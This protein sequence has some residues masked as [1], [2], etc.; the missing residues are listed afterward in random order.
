MNFGNFLPQAAQTYCLW[1]A[2]GVRAEYVC[3]VISYIYCKRSQNIYVIAQNKY[4]FALISLSFSVSWSKS[5]LFCCV[6]PQVRLLTT[7]AAC[8][9]VVMSESTEEMVDIACKP[10]AKCLL[11]C[12]GRFKCMAFFFAFCYQSYPL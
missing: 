8:R 10:L 1:K 3:E 6:S 9:G 5:G 12:R 2:C 4:C 7:M 11:I